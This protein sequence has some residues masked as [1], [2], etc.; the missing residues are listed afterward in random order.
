M[1]VRT[2]AWMAGALACMLAAGS[3][4]RAQAISET[5]ADT[6]AEL[7][8]MV[9]L[10]PVIFAGQVVAVRGADSALHGNVEIEFAVE[11]AVR[12]VSG[13]RYL[14]REWAGLWVAGDAPFRVGQ[15]YLMLLH[16]PGAAGLSSPVDGP[17][18]AIP[19]GSSSQG[20]GRVVD[21]RWVGARVLR[22]TVYREIAQPVGPAGMAHPE[23][24][25]TGTLE[26]QTPTGAPAAQ[27][28]EYADM[29]ALLR[30][31]VKVDDGGR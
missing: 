5:S 6:V 10:A 7:H 8:G 13:S 11:D 15:R 12:G 24:A 1:R 9:R 2:R 18:G 31:W 14:L 26:P 25:E 28:S 17:D 19:V 16:A 27:S 3:A 23:V 22:P 29:M 20:D 30:S 21:L 4:A